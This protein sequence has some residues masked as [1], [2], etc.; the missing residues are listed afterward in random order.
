MRSSKVSQFGEKFSRCI[1]NPVECPLSSLSLFAHMSLQMQQLKN[2][3]GG[4]SHNLILGNF[5][6][7][8][9]NFHLD[10]IFLTLLR[11]DV[12][13]S[14]CILLNVSVKR[15]MFWTTVLEKDET[16]FMPSTLSRQIL[17]F[18][19]T[20]KGM[21]YFQTFILKINRGLWNTITIKKEQKKR[22][23][24][25]STVIRLLQTQDSFIL[26]CSTLLQYD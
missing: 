21:L 7:N 19:E 2:H 12:C 15:K 1:S 10:Q 20:I 3:W 22:L 11:E 25:V 14:V 4:S 5:R 8:C 6:K 16:C 18:F 26:Q 13:I 23:K 9:S 17:W 24:K